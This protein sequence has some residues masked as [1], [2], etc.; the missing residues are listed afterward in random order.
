[1]Q[2]MYVCLHM[3]AIKRMHILINLCLCC[4][5]TPF[6]SLDT[7]TSFKNH[8]KPFSVIINTR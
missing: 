5:V 3:F 1:M 4:F 7:L 8:S 2:H 6:Y